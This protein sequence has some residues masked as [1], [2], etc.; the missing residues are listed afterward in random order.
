MLLVFNAVRGRG[1]PFGRGHLLRYLL[2]ALF[3]T[4]IP[5]SI[6]YQA[7]VHLP[8]GILSIIISLVPM[9][10]LPK[11]LVLGMER[12]SLAR[13]VGLFCGAVAIVMIA[14]P[15][16]SLPDPSKSFWVLILALSPLMYAA[17]GTWVAR[18]G[19]LDLEPGQVLLGA[20]LV[21][22][23]L[24]F[25]L[26][27]FTGQFINPL[28]AWGAPEVALVSSSVIHAF[29]YTSYVWLVGRTGS[30]F[31]SQVSYFVTGTGVLWAMLIQG[32][33]YSGW[34]WAALAL[35]LVGLFLVQPRKAGPLVLPDQESDE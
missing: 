25:P 27:I 24:A 35:M 22:L 12:F 3:G 20:S 28:R 4:V 1:L 31:A 21:G 8:S 26:A 23:V 10:A 19:I 11:A 15:D 18:F 9:F 13:F 32:E 7:A 2:V 17:E 16:T 5:N 6:S 30:V 14:A 29:V 34:V 33:S